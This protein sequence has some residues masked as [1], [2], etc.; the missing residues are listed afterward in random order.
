MG[1]SSSIAFK[2]CPLSEKAIPANSG[3]PKCLVVGEAKLYRELCNLLI[4][5]TTGRTKARLQLYLLGKSTGLELDLRVQD[6]D[7]CTYM[8]NME[9]IGQPQ[10]SWPG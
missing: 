9:V 3:H 2:G 5:P 7:A 1:S 10:K 8:K 4:L 6:P